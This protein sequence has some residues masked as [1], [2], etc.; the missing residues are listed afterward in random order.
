MS[1]VDLLGSNFVQLGTF[2]E[3]LGPI[4]AQLGP[5]VAQ[6]GPTVAQ[7]G[8][9]VAQLGSFVGGL[10]TF[11]AR[12]GWSVAELGPSESRF[13]YSLR[14]H[15]ISVFSI[16]NQ[17]DK[18]ETRKINAAIRPQQ[19]EKVIPPKRKSDSGRRFYRIWK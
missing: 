19:Q 16:V 10:G 8:S 17:R 13:C 18:K 1:N 12:L 6:L 2:D 5:T 14:Y 9:F 7:L 15:G 4:V 3:K 11:V